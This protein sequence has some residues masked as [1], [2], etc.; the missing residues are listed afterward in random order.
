[1]GKITISFL[2]ISAIFSLKCN[3]I[4]AQ[5]LYLE[6]NTI[7]SDTNYNLS[8]NDFDDLYFVNKYSLS[9]IFEFPQFIY[10]SEFLNYKTLTLNS[11]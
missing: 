9:D 1:M 6:L 8:F 5:D 2:I 4:N 10:K 3:N 7:D 11:D